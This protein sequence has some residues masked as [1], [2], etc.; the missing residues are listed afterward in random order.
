MELALVTHTSSVFK[1]LKSFEI[2][3]KKYR[4]C[5]S[6]QEALQCKICPLAGI[7][8]KNTSYP[9]LTGNKVPVDYYAK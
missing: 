9:Y 7:E 6:V 8:E 5:F 4:G 2:K 1:F 3:K